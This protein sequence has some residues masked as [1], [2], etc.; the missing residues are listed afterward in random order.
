MKEM[1][2]ARML[3]RLNARI[4]V[5]QVGS[6]SIPAR[7]R[8][9]GTAVEC[10]VPTWA[11]IGDTLGESGEAMLLAFVEMGPAL[12]WVFMRGRASLVTDA[13]P[14]WQGLPGAGSSNRKDLYELVRLE[15]IRIELADE[16]RGWGYRETVDL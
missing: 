16:Q 9:K 2:S 5:L 3:D 4:A 1:L 10:L 8:V 12:S 7:I 14:E 15:P 11:G 13:D 6:Y